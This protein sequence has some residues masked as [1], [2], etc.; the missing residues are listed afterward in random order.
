MDVDDLHAVWINEDLK[1]IRETVV[2]ARILPSRE[3]KRIPEFN[4]Q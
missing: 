1:V 2:D 4:K 3:F